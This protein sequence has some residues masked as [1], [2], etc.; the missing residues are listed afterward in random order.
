MMKS[1]S[2][3]LSAVTLVVWNRLETEAPKKGGEVVGEPGVELKNWTP[4]SGDDSAAVSDWKPESP[5]ARPGIRYADPA[6]AILRRCIRASRPG[7]GW[8][9]RR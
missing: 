3:S 1:C 6:S 9:G 8:A 7:S 2:E 4:E 5:P